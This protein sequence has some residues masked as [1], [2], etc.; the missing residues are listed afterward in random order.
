MSGR[1]GGWG[2]AMRHRRPMTGMAPMQR[3]KSTGMWPG[4]ER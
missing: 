3:P 2:P 4:M 1:N